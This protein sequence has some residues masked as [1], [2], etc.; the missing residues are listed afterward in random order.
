MGP[1]GF[2][3]ASRP[4]HGCPLFWMGPPLGADGAYNPRRWRL[5]YSSRFGFRRPPPYTPKR[6]NQCAALRHKLLS[7]GRHWQRSAK[8]KV[9]EMKQCQ[10]CDQ[11]KEKGRF[12]ITTKL[13]SKTTRLDAISLCKKHSDNLSNDIWSLVFQFLRGVNIE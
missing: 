12:Y 2:S 1:S 8:A 10:V 6:D 13:V 7:R 9:N 11:P 3:N 4:S 5:A